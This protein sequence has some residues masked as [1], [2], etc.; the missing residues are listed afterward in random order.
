M[1]SSSRRPRVR[2]T[3][4]AVLLLMSSIEGQLAAQTPPTASQ[5]RD[6]RNILAS[7]YLLQDRNQDDVVDFVRARIVLPAR[8]SEAEI[9][10]AANLA[11]RLGFETSALNLGLAASDD[12]RVA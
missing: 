11:A 6:L 10:A 9:A 8:P 7:G 12:E 5:P 1:Y 4:T 2:I 3:I